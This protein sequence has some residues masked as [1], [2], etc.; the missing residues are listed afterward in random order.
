MIDAPPGHIR[1]SE[2]DVSIILNTKELFEEQDKKENVEVRSKI[3]LFSPTEEVLQTWKHLDVALLSLLQDIMLT[4]IPS[5][6]YL[7]PVA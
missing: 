6:Q 2:G 1:D 7:L 4:P 3:K 5:N